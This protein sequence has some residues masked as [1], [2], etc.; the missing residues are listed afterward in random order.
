MPPRTANSPRFSTRSTRE[1]AAHTDAYGDSWLTEIKRSAQTAG[2]KV[3]AEE[4]YNR[5]DT[6]VTGQILKI[7][8][9]NPD[10]VLIGAS[11]TPAATPRR[12]G[13]GAASWRI[14]PWTS[15]RRPGGRC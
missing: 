14:G 15:I 3:V 9:T 13:C 12:W 6:S 7:V 10:A 5:N 2:I 11:G 8:A 1:Y 4:K